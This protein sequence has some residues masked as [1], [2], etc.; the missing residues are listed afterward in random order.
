MVPCEGARCD[1]GGV[2]FG[3]AEMHTSKGGGLVGWRRG[4]EIGFRLMD[5]AVVGRI[6]CG[7]YMDT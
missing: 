5:W 1:G 2:T 3:G 6:P 4:R 7:I